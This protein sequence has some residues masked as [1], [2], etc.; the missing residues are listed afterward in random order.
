[1]SNTLEIMSSLARE[2][3]DAILAIYGE[4]DFGIETKDDA[5]PLTRAD[6]K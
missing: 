2:A 3:G 5:S 1:M 4:D 6:H